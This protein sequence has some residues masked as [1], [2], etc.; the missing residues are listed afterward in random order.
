MSRHW[1]LNLIHENELVYFTPVE[2]QFGNT[3]LDWIPKSNRVFCLS[4]FQVERKFNLLRHSTLCTSLQ[5][6]CNSIC[7]P[8]HNRGEVLQLNFHLS[9]IGV[10]RQ[11]SLFVCRDCDDD[12]NV[13]KW[14]KWFEQLGECAREKQTQPYPMNNESQTSA[15]FYR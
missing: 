14:F 9:T 13:I 8:Y 5:F 3:A 7:M 11:A 4:H 15:I 6:V 1:F 10:D 2:T 12:D